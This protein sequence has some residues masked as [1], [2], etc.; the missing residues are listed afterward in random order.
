[1]AAFVPVGQWSPMLQ[2]LQVENQKLKEELEY[3]KDYLTQYQEA[4]ADDFFRKLHQDAILAS[5]V[6]TNKRLKNLYKSKH[7]KK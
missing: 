7:A 5:L 4:A 1:M 6:K 3:T 2:E